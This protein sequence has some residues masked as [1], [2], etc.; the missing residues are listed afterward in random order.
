LN[1]IDVHREPH[2]DGRASERDGVLREWR[3]VGVVSFDLKGLG[4]SPNRL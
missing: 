4:V 3:F 1:A 2:G